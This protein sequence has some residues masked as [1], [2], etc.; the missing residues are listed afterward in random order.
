MSR[1]R[2]MLSPVSVAVL[3]LLV[4]MTSIQV[5]ASVAK[6]LFPLIGAQ[7]VTTLRVFFAALMLLA[8]WRPWRRKLTRKELWVVVVYGAALGGMN[9]TFYLALER[10]PLGIAVAIEFTG[11]LAVALL[12]TRRPIDFVWAFLAVAGILMIL[13]LAESS[14]ALDWVGVFWA[15]VAGTCWAFYILFGQ[16]AGASVHGGT[17][18]SLGMVTA[19]LLVCPFG[20]ARAGTQLLDVSLLPMALAVAVLSS[21]L[22]YS[23]EM[24]ALKRLPARTFG[25]LMSLE[26]ALA[27]LSGLVFLREQLTVI[28]WA[29]I[30]C[31]ILASAGSSATSKPAV[32]EV[33]EGVD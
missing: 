4:A 16:R 19:A 3:T 5:G 15:L 32:A 17:A 31:V 30:G 26:P 8:F 20:V 2:T 33:P 23:L 14:K 18:T 6:R 10:I 1:V 12:S 22:P 28:Q 7:G 13:P 11:P 24:I 29:A 21:A 9:M 25:I 27:A